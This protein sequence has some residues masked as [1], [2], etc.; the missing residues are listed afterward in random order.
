MPDLQAAAARLD[1]FIAR[2]IEETRTPA[3]AVALTDR[4]RLL[5]VTAHGLADQIAGRAAT[6]ETLFEIG[7]IGKSFTAVAL[8]QEHE[9]GRLDLHAPI[10]QYLPWFSVQS[11]YAPITTHHLLSHTSGLPGGSDFTPGSRFEVYALRDQATGYAPGAHFHYSNVGYKLLG[12]LLETLAGQPYAEVIQQRILTPLGM[13]ASAPAITNDI[14]PRLAAGYW[15]YYDDRPWSGRD[16]LAPATWFEYGMGDGSLACTPA[17]LAA[18]LRMLLNRGQGPAG[19][20]LS[21][22]SFALISQQVTTAWSDEMFYGYGL[23]S[24]T[25]DG[26]ACFSHAGEMIGYHAMMLGDS[27]AGLGVVLFTNGPL[28]GMAETEWAL[29]L[30][31]AAYTGEPLPELPPARATARTV[32]GAAEYAGV[33]HGHGKTLHLVAED[34]Q[35]ILLYDGARVTLEQRAP[36][37]FLADHPAFRHFY[38]SFGREDGVVVEAFYGGEWYPGERYSGPR[39]F[40]YPPEWDAYV[41]HYRAHNPWWTNFRII[42]R[43]DSLALVWW[44]AWRQALTPLPDGSFRVGEAHAPERLRFDAIVEGQALRAHYSGCDFYRVPTP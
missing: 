44:G 18:F 27:E 35:L 34:D 15:G 26:R 29:G 20:I 3:I 12:C 30:L 23:V 39:S 9:A 40:P 19:R 11:E 10:T 21:E 32:E 16:P 13:T 41:G 8:M 4:E 14:R 7:S 5:H 24:H 36:N 2:R 25:V 6:P 22:A 17:D 33:Y 43:K 38:L 1:Q 28:D 31:R 37:V 42:I